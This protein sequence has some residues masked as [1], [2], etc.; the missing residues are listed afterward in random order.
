MGTFQHLVEFVTQEF[1][2]QKREFVIQEIW[3]M[4]I[5]SYRHILYNVEVIT[6]KM[7]H[8]GKYSFIWSHALGS[9]PLIGKL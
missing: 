5:G 1:I 2:N 6:H 7:V 9:L 8:D 3:T 4:H